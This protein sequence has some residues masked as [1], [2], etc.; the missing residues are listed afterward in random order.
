MTLISV[1]KYVAWN[2]MV[3]GTVTLATVYNV[4]PILAI[5]NWFFG[6]E[7]A[8]YLITVFLSTNDDFWESMLKKP[9]TLEPWKAAVE[10]IWIVYMFNLG[11]VFNG[12]CMA[13]TALAYTYVVICKY[14]RL[15]A[16]QKP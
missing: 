10:P 16:S 3:V 1:M 5:A 2:A 9:E 11:H 4:E 6:I 14:A 7:A 12:V 13:F 15:S 8:L